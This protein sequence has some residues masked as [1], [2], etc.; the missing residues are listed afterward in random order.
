MAR[1]SKGITQF[2]YHQPTNHTC[3]YSPATG[4]HRP[5][6]G[7]HCTYPRRDGQAE[8]TWVTGY[9]LRL[10]LLSDFNL[11]AV[12]QGVYGTEVSQWST[13]LQ[14]QSEGQ[15]PPEAEAV[16]RHCLQILTRET[17]TIRNC[18]INWHPDS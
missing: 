6:A 15:S 7:T 1:D 16:C 5:L 4:H 9:M 14:G 13:G 17:I 12:A 11:G 2:T 10:D 8:L 3:L 18:G